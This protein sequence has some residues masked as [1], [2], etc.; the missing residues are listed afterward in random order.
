MNN[1][2]PSASAPQHLKTK[3]AKLKDLAPKAR[4]A[5]R[6]KGGPIIHPGLSIK[7]KQ[8]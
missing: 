8:S 7:G 2:K 6:V 3:K 5:Q 1:R 4:A